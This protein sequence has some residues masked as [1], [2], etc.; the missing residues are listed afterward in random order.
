MKKLRTILCLVAAACLALPSAAQYATTAFRL[1]S[2]TAKL[3]RSVGQTFTTSVTLPLNDLPV[4]SGLSLSGSAS[5]LNGDDAYIGVTLLDTA[6]CEHLVYET[7]PLM[8][9]DL[10]CTLNDVALETAALDNVRPDSLKIFLRNARLTI[11]ALHYAGRTTATDWQT[12]RKNLLA[13]Q[14]SYTLERLNQHLRERNMT[15]SVGETCYSSLTFDEKRRLLG[16]G[17]NLMGGFEYYTGGI[18]VMPGAL[19]VPAPKETDPFVKEFD[20]RNRH[21]KNWI[22]PSK[23]QTPLGCWAYGPISALEAQ[24]NIYLNKLINYDLSEQE[25]LSCS[26]GKR[27]DKVTGD[28]AGG[29]TSDAVE[30]IY[31][32]GVVTE[33]CFPLID[34]EAN[35]SLKCNAPTDIIRS[36][37]GFKARPDDKNTDESHETHFMKMIIKSP[38]ITSLTFNYES[39]VW[40]HCVT[41]IGFKRIEVGDSIY[42]D[43]SKSVVVQIEEDNPLIGQVTWIIKDN[44]GSKWGENGCAYIILTN[45]IDYGYYNPFGTISSLLH[46]RIVTDNDNDGFYWWGMGDKPEGLP[47]WVENRL[48]GDDTDYR[49]GAI[50]EYGNMERIHTLGTLLINDNE[51]WDWDFFHYVSPIIEYGGQLT[52]SADDIRFYRDVSILVQNGGTLI[53][54]GCRVTQADIHVERGGNLIMKNN[55]VLILADDDSLL[56]DKGAN[57]EISNSQI[58]NQKDL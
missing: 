33:D 51:V 18:F 1:Q 15:W 17:F 7:Y 45:A 57:M 24:T 5:L 3:K 37:R 50:D 44:H 31:N 36:S 6:G 41:T 58:L 54:D 22:T 53:I 56:I 29:V 2:A 23:P 30:Y 19:S 42:T 11:D 35:C 26:G 43:I 25:I 27:Y 48:D 21:G 13:S 46:E 34:R 4:L 14:K 40:A 49:L 55:A 39:G 38:L 12:Q 16:D 32:Y 8:A 47:W 20:W 9:D 28:Y 10:S 52:L